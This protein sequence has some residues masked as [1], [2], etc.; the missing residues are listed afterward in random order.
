M[1]QEQA[2]LFLAALGT[3]LSLSLALLIARDYLD[4]PAAKAF[5]M[6]LLCANVHMY[7]IF[8]PENWFVLSWNVQSMAPA[9]FWIATRYTFVDPDEPRTLSWTLAVTSFLLPFIW[10]LAG[11]PQEL[12]TVLIDMPQKLEYLVVML[13]IFEIVNNWN[14][15]LVEARRR[16]RGGLL[17]SMGIATGWSI[18]SYR[19]SIGGDAMRYLGI[20]ISLIIMVGFLLQSRPELWK[21]RS[22]NNNPLAQHSP[23][24]THHADASPEEHPVAEETAPLASQNP[25][26]EQ[27]HGLMASGFYRQENLTLAILAQALE[28]PEYKLRATI[29]KSLGYN[30]FNEYINQLRIGEAANRLVTEKETPVTNIALDVGYRTMSSFNRAFRKIHDMTPSQYRDSDGLPLESD[31]DDKNLNNPVTI[32]Q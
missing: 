24:I 21:L 1:I 28:I 9:M 6:L 32:N 23:E 19:F 4:T 10:F 12:R 5:I 14:N 3:G 30:N 26:L 13:G 15:D 20:D 16:L 22:I 2:E 18:F 25:H 27:L 8:M 7:H 29:N 31:T 17:L 11:Q